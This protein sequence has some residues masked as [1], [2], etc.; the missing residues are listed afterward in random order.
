[1]GRWISPFN[2][3]SLQFFDMFDRQCAYL[4]VC[5]SFRYTLVISLLGNFFIDKSRKG[6]TPATSCSI[7]NSIWMFVIQLPE[8]QSKD[9]DPPFQRM[10]TSSRYLFQVFKYGRYSLLSLKTYSSSNQIIKMS[11]IGPGMD[12]LSVFQQSAEKFCHLFFWN[13]FPNKFPIT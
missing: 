3:P 13:E 7:V 10:Y 11:A 1:M 8:K 5:V 2:I 6:K 4:W 12:F 9:S